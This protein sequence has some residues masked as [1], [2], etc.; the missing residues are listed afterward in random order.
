MMPGLAGHNR[1]LSRALGGYLLAV[2]AFEVV[3]LALAATTHTVLKVGLV[4]RAGVGWVFPWVAATFGERA[5]LLI[6]AGSAV[7][8]LILGGLL[9]SGKRP[10]RTYVCTELLLAAPTVYVAISLVVSGGGHVL[11]RADGWIMLGVFLV[12]TVVPV[13]LAIRCLRSS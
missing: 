5:I 3:V 4:L 6:E 2:A 7:W 8:L 12:C 13:A 9:I 11:V 10:L 1:A